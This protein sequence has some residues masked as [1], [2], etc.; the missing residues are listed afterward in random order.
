MLAGFKR[1]KS[2]KCQKTVSQFV[3][4]ILILLEI[5]HIL[6]I[7]KILYN[8]PTPYSGVFLEKL[9]VLHLFNKLQYSKELFASHILNQINPVPSYFLKIHSNIIRPF[10]PGSSKLSLSLKFPHQSPVCT[11]SLSHKCHTP[12]PSKFSLILSFQLYLVRSA[13]FE[14]PH[15]VI[16][17]NL[18]L[19]RLSWAQI[20]S[21]S[22]II[23]HSQHIFS[24]TVYEQY[25]V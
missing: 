16:S 3:I 12:R 11:S 9:I 22:H 7:Y 2:R 4:N 23:V 15:Y 5:F 21:S 17:S 20:C 14:G 6:S 18:L 19:P 13:D 25:T 24:L 1:L 10:R 8:Y